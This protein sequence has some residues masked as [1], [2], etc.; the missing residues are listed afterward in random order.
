MELCFCAGMQGVAESVAH[1]FCRALSKTASACLSKCCGRRLGVK[2]RRN[3]MATGCRKR[4]PKNGPEKWSP[5]RD[6]CICWYNQWSPFSG[7]FFGTAFRRC[8]RFLTHGFW[9]SMQA[10]AIWRWHRFIEAWKLI[11]LC[12]PDFQSCHA[13]A[14]IERPHIK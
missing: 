1:V 10:F 11:L 2:C 4:G 5:N 6:H 13:Y 12:A 14:M 8:F 7:P 3:V 9:D